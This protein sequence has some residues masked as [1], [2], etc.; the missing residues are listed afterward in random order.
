[1][2]NG[3]TA[4]ANAWKNLPSFSMTIIHQQCIAHVCARIVTKRL[5]PV[6]KQMLMLLI[7]S[8]RVD[9]LN[10]CIVICAEN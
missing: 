3:K 1:M 6:L 4:Q 8:N 10:L 5:Q 2:T 9:S 7:D